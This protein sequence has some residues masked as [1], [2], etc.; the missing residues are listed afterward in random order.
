MRCSFHPEIEL[1]KNGLRL[2]DRRQRYLCRP[3]GGQP[4]QLT[5]PLTEELVGA[6]LTCRRDWERGLPVARRGRF[7][8]T[9]AANFLCLIGGGASMAEAAEH[10]RLDRSDFTQRRAIITGNE[11]A[12]GEEVSHDGRMAADWLERYGAPVAHALMP[13]AWPSGTIAVD[14][15][16]FSI[17]S[18][19]P[20]DH[21]TKQGHPFPGGA[22]AFAVLAGVSRG[23]GGRL[24]V[25]HI[26]ATPDD[27]KP[28]WVAFFRGLRG[29]PDTVLS[30]PDP[31]IDYAIKEV[32]PDD[33]PLHP[34]STWHYWSKVLEKFALARKYPYTDELC[35]ESE[36]AFQNPT[37]FP[38]WRQRAMVEAPAPVQ[39]WLKKKG[40]E[41]LAGLQGSQP[42][43]TIG[44]LET[45]LRQRVGYVLEQG[46][47]GIRNLPRLDIRLSLIALEQNGQ[48]TPAKVEKILLDRLAT[49]RRL[50]RRRSLDGHPYDPHWLLASGA[51]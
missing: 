43:R 50:L 12:L 30:D 5:A 34:L 11:L 1:V 21:P 45:F 9:Q 27:H 26:R 41:I 40:D 22:T 36:K 23:P 47:G 38:D 31:Q 48:L 29:K 51:A 7:L 6:C 14:A 49:D 46:R 39:A 37:L 8:L 17:G 4:H 44:G 33:P 10:V 28:S 13:K 2:G 19:Y 20:A 42:P 15:K 18:R 32:W 25:V 35:R 24:R 3:A 16:T